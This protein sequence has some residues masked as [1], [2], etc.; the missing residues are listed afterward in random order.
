M[1]MIS[2]NDVIVVITDMRMLMASLALVLK[3]HLLNCLILV[4]VASK[5]IR[6]LKGMLIVVLHLL[7]LNAME[8]SVK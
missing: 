3:I 7:Y 1:M 8:V 6:N 5:L 2:L 4:L